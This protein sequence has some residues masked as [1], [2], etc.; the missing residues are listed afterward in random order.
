MAVGISSAITVFYTRIFQT[1]SNQF[2][3]FKVIYATVIFGF[4]MARKPG[5]IQV[6][7]MFFTRK[8]SKKSQH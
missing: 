2:K 7:K 4:E 1:S 6:E 5:R 3:V 8:L